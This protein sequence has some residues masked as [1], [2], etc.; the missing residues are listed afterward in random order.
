MKSWQVNICNRHDVSSE[1]ASVAKHLRMTRRHLLRGTAYVPALQDT[2]LRGGDTDTN[3]CIVGG[4]IGALHGLESIPADMRAAVLERDTHS[5]GNA[6][7]DFLQPTDLL[8]RIQH[9]YAL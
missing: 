7:P 3:A 4:M 9:L 8:K 5:P 1:T 2:L 6:R